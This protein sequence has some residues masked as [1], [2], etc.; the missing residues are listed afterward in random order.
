MTSATFERQIDRLRSEWPRAYGEERKAALWSV[1]FR[2]EDDLFEAAVTHLLLEHKGDRAPV[3]SDIHKA[4][5]AIREK[6]R[7]N[8]GSG[9][10]ARGEETQAADPSFIRRC[11][12]LVDKISR[13][14]LWSDRVPTEAEL[15][16]RREELARQA[17]EIKRLER[18]RG[19]PPLSRRDYA[20]GER[21][22][23]EP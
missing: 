17:E 20:A 3:A 22:Q 9:Q 1:F 21:D 11:V 12:A 23:E 5:E 6:R 18:L 4:I 2:V 15:E 7:V 14:G 8:R 16:A 19:K 13:G 10:V